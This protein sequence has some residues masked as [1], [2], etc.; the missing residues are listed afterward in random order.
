[1]AETKKARPTTVKLSKEAS[2]MLTKISEKLS[3]DKC[4][5]LEDFII[6]LNHI[7]DYACAE[8]TYGMVLSPLEGQLV[9][10]VHP[11]QQF[12]LVQKRIH[13]D[14]ARGKTK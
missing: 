12:V 10:Q 4:K 11:K 14:I 13:R 1:M 9:I 3:M 7:F 8:S 2:A 6:G 5:I